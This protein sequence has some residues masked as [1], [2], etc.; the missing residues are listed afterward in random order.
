MENP[1]PECVLPLR[2]ILDYRQYD[3]ADFCFKY[4][5]VNFAEFEEM[6]EALEEKAEEEQNELTLNRLTDE[7]EKFKSP[8]ILKQLNKHKKYMDNPNDRRIGMLGDLVARIR[9]K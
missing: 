2:M 1:N 4:P 5:S 7:Y 9:K 6:L 8:S 3:E